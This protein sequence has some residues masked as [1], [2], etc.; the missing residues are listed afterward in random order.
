MEEMP[1]EQPAPEAPPPV[2][3]PRRGR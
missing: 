2:R 1:V 3:Q